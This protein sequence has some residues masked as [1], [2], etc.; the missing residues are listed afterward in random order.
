MLLALNF[1]NKNQY[2]KYPFK[3]TSSLLADSG[4]SLK[5][6]LIVN[7]SITSTYGNHRVYVSQIFKKDDLVRVA[8]SSVLDDSLLGIFSGNL[9]EDF[10]TLELTPLINFVAGNITLGALS[11]WVDVPRILSF[12]SA[13]AELEESAVFCFTPP[14]VTSI[15]DKL[16]Q[17]LTGN[18]NF[19][20]LTNV[21]KFSDNANR[22]VLLQAT[23]PENIESLADKSSFLNNCDN[24]VIKNI[25]GVTP[26]VGGSI[27]DEND[28]NIYIVG[29]L[30]ITFYGVSND[31]GVIN[32]S[33]NDVTL[34]S[35]CGQK[36]KLIPP[37]DISGFTINNS[38]FIDKYYSRPA[39]T[40]SMYEGIPPNYP[41]MIPRRYAS[42]FYSTSHPEYYYWP[43]FIKPEYYNFWARATGPLPG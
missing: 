26:F 40:Q 16:N 4:Y 39:F 33:T 11:E 27:P 2:R 19:G 8:I 17:S 6:S 25:N 20:V 43:Q 15:R 34:T 38:E 5:D 30:P 10:T 9:I 31:D 14:N 41:Y 13:S 18:V 22:A 24:P 7:C 37:S 12:Q 42:N 32:T 29:V 36:N 1:N 35:L 28:G 3:Q 23:S 21:N